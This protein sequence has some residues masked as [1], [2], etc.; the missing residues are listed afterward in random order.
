M[1]KVLTYLENRAVSG[2]F[3]TI[4]PPKPSPPSECVLPPYQRQG[5]H[6]RR[7]VKGGGQYFG[8]RQTLGQYNPST[9]L[10]I[11]FVEIR[12]YTITT[13]TGNPTE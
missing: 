6:T 12:R 1:H 4:D 13:W 11:Y 2:V 8:R 9:L 3:R 10:C 7:A 5:V